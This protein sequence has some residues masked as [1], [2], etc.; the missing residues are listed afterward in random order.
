[1]EDYEVEEEELPLPVNINNM[2]RTESIK[3]LRSFG[4][5]DSE[6]SER[7]YGFGLRNIPSIFRNNSNLDDQ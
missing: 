3:S 7:D 2:A 5:R 4:R 1:M 6:R